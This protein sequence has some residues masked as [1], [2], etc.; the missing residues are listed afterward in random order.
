MAF[1][2]ADWAFWQARRAMSSQRAVIGG[3]GR[4]SKTG[5]IATVF[6][7]TGHLGRYVVNHLGRQ[8]TQVVVPFRGEENSTRHLK[9]MGDLGQIVMLK[10]DP[11]NLTSIER[12]VSRSNVVINLIGAQVPTMNFS[13]HDANLKIARLVARVAKERGIEQYLH[14]SDIRA[15]PNSPSEYARLKW[16]AEGEVR[17]IFPSATIARVAPLFG[18]EDKLTNAYGILMRY[19]PFIPMICGDYELQP[20]YSGDA[21]MAI[22]RIVREFEPAALGKVVELVGPE[23]FTHRELCD[24]VAELTVFKDRYRSIDISPRLAEPVLKVMQRLPRFRPMFHL[25]EIRMRQGRN[26]L[27]SKEE[28]VAYVETGSQKIYTSGLLW[29]RRFREAVSMN[30]VVGERH[31]YDTFFDHVDD[32]N[33]I[34]KPDFAEPPKLQQRH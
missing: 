7:A 15:D 16:Q 30:Q 17:E 34:P 11:R 22:A 5:I 8:G 33:R 3:G 31:R 13:L 2:A 27:P 29:L 14:V 9:V 18:P 32:A 23:R 1:C 24:K 4:S 25:E 28:Q 21:A 20:I 26:A 6:G 12:A 10:Y 19:A